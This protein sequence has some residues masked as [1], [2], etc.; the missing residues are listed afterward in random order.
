LPFAADAGTTAIKRAAPQVSATKKRDRSRGVLPAIR[1]KIREIPEA[2][3]IPRPPTPREMNDAPPTILGL[4]ALALLALSG[5]AIL[6]YVI[7]F[8]RG[9][10]T[11]SA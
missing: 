8:I 10:G 7:R 3:A 4:L 11:R 9:P 1:R 5:I 2:F 6:A